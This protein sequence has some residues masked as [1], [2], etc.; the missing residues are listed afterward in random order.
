MVELKSI[1]NAHF[2]GIGGVSMSA[3]AMMLKNMGISVSGSDFH[4]SPTTQYLSEQGIPVS[5]G[6]SAENIPANTDFVVYTAAIAKDNPEFQYAVAN[7]ITCISRAKLLGQIMEEYQKSIAV[8]G[9]HGKTT[10]T[11]MLSHILTAADVDPTITVGAYLDKLKA[12]YRIGNSEYFLLEACEYCNSFHNFFPNTS[13]ILNISE[14]HLDFFKDLADIHNSF[15]QFGKNTKENLVVN[16]ELLSVPALLDGLDLNIISFGKG[17]DYHAE[18]ISYQ[19]SGA[20][21]FD[22]FHK[23]D[24]LMRIELSVFGEHNILNALAAIAAA[25]TLDIPATAMQEGLKEFRGAERR[26]QHKGNLAGIEIYDDY[27]HHP[28]EIAST[29]AAVKNLP[30][31][32]LWLIFQPHTYSRTKLLFDD[33]V[34]VLSQAENVILTD[35]YAAREKNTYQI[36]SKDLFEAIH[37]HN[38]NS[39]YFETFDEIENFVLEQAIPGD[40][41]ITMGAGDVYF[42]G[43]SLLSL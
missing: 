5:F 9:T 1:Q 6:H 12:N 23:K 10:V 33:F 16:A 31:K 43:E 29:L 22:V 24:F 34:K 18:N 26:F 30:H 8:S 41:L 14:D 32:N 35:I 27:A 38:P 28:E 20:P 13:I 17:G 3:L 21:S 42:I 11:S 7:Q 19:V 15:H 4:I 2:I 40:M 37:V 36:S 25:H 39:Y